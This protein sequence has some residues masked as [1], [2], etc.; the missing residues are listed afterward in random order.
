M[1]LEDKTVIDQELIQEV[2][3]RIVDAFHPEKVILFGSHARGDAKPDSDL[4]LIVV[5][6]TNVPYWLRPAL[7]ERAL[8]ARTWGLDVVVLTPMEYDLAARTPGHLV[9]LTK[10]EASTLYAA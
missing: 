9:A 6:P 10:N 3:R 7:I 5:M 1:R 8:P 2:T 4:D